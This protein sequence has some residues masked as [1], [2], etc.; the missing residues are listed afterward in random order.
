MLQVCFVCTWLTA[1]LRTIE[2]ILHEVIR[3]FGKLQNKATEGSRE[4]LEYLLQQ[5]PFTCEK[6]KE[7]F[8]RWLK[9]AEYEQTSPETQTRPSTLGTIRRASNS[10]KTKWKTNLSFSNIP[11][12]LESSNTSGFVCLFCE[13]F[14]PT[15]KFDSH[16]TLCSQI[17]CDLAS[18]YDKFGGSEE[19]IAKICE[20]SISIKESQEKAGEIDSELAVLIQTLQNQHC[21]LSKK[22]QTIDK[23]L[24]EIRNILA[25]PM[26]LSVPVQVIGKKFMDH[27]WYFE[28]RKLE[29]CNLEIF[30]SEI[31]GVGD[32]STV[33]KGIYDGE[34]VAIVV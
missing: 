30:K 26:A 21:F 7:P 11:S 3:C 8:V 18:V 32:S 6:A 16:E 4:D 10:V 22:M 20:I 25:K 19:F 5:L 27:F 2:Q 28:M 14:Y 1:G 31:L 13:N 34:P 29:P 9:E 24:S 17:N 12:P 23:S 33:Y 15:Q